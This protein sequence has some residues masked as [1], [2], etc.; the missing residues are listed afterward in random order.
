MLK[1][2]S[3]I[4]KELNDKCIAEVIARIEDIESENVGIIAAQDVIDIVTQNL[5]SEIYNMAL[6]DTKKLLQEKI[7]DFEF[8]ID[9]LE[10][11]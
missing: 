5:G 11:S 7:S 1:K 6:R 10:Q 8:E 3:N 9:Q 2:F 4:P